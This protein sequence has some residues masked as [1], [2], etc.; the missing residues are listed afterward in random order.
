[1]KIYTK[2]LGQ[3]NLDQARI[4]IDTF[5][6]TADEGLLAVVAQT[7]N[8]AVVAKE[9]HKQKSSAKTVGALRYA[10]LAASLTAC[11]QPA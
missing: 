6:K 5:I 2:L 7:E 3:V 1:M 4:L 8:D 11:R 9:M 10:N